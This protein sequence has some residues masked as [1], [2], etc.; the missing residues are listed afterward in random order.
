MY[1]VHG[2]SLSVSSHLLAEWT[3]SIPQARVRHR[4]GGGPF[5]EGDWLEISGEPTPSALRGG[6]VDGDVDHYTP[7]SGACSGMWPLYVCTS[8]HCT[9][10]SMTVTGEGEG[11]AAAPIAVGRQSGLDTI[12]AISGLDFVGS[13]APHDPLRGKRSTVAMSWPAP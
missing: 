4:W 12:P 13:T 11:W 2:P 3:T 1:I 9:G 5:G 7:C 6:S 10:G 8:P